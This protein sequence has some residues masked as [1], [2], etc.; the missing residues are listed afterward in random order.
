[1]EFGVL[2]F[3]EHPAGGK[4]EHR[5]FKEQLDTLRAAEE[6]G[7]DYIWAPEHVLARVL[8]GARNMKVQSR[9][10]QQR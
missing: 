8:R 1:M 9:L 5:I 10:G 4:T 7:F 3:F 6:L 2:N